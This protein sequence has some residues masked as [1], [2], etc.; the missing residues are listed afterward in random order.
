MN[1]Y[2]PCKKVQLADRFKLVTHFTAEFRPNQFKVH[3]VCKDIKVITGV[4]L[5]TKNRRA[6][7]S[8]LRAT[9]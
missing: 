4:R 9:R 7:K 3:H 2:L 6:V 8:K 5:G 1:G